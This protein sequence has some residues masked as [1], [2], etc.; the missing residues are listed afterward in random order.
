MSTPSQRLRLAPH[1]RACHCDDQVI[2]LDLRRNLYLGV[3]GRH[4]AAPA[5]VIDGWPSSC[6]PGEHLPFAAAQ[7]AALA[8]PLISQ[9]LLTDQPVDHPPDQVIDEATASL[10]AQDAVR[11]PTLGTRRFLRVLRSAATAALWLRCRSLLATTQAV[12]ARRS[13]LGEDVSRPASLATVSSAVAAYERLRPLVYTAQ[14]RCLHDSLAL[15]SFLA[16]EGIFARW[17][18]GVQTRPFAAHSWVQSGG[19]VLNDQHEHVRRFRPIV[20]V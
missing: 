18:I 15:V 12:A 14:G 5:M 17:V 20:V 16:K 10:N 19:L 3:G 8:R 2:L 13:R 6:Q 4:L 7:I 11:H 1:V 9:G